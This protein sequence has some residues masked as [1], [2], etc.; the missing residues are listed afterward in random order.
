MPRHNRHSRTA[1][2]AAGLLYLPGAAVCVLLLPV[3]AVRVPNLLGCREV[4]SG[5]MQALYS[6]W[7]ASTA[8]IMYAR[9]WCAVQTDLEV[10]SRI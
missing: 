10:D 7:C 8:S 6:S 2:A 9:I 1:R 5:I 4:L 3:A